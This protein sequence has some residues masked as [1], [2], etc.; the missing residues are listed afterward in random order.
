MW[1]VV[2]YNP[3]ECS[4]NKTFFEFSLAGLCGIF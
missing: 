4:K 1:Y 2:A 3:E